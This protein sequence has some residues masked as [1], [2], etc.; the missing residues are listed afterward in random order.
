[1]LEATTLKIPIISSDCKTG[2]RE[3]LQGNKGGL[4]F[5]VGNSKELAK[6]ILYSK[7]NYKIMKKKIN[8]SFNNLHRFDEK[9]NLKKYLDLIN[10]H[11]K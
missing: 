2:P 4:L 9:L 11:L 1:M 7:D 8:F 10:L 3:I 6:K 5:K